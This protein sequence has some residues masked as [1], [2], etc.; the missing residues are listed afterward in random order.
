MRIVHVV[1]N[2]GTIQGN[3][4][5]VLYLAAGQR[6]RGSDVLVVTD[7]QGRFT[8][9]CDQQGTPVIVAKGFRL[10]MDIGSVEDGGVPGETDP[11]FTA[12]RD[13]L[14]RQFSSFRADLIHCHDEI[15]AYA[16]ISAGNR[17]NIPCALTV[18]VPPAGPFPYL[19]AAAKFQVISGAKWL[20][21]KLHRDGVPES[22]LHYVPNGTRFSTAANAAEADPDGAPR[23]VLV[24]RVSYEKGADIAI[25]AM[26]ELQRRRGSGCPQLHVYGGGQELPYYVE[27]ARVLGLQEYIKFHGPQFDIIDRCR[28]TDILVVTSRGETGP[29]VVLEAMSRGMPVVS[30]DV[31]DV[32]MMLP[33]RRYGLIVPVAKIVMLADAIDAT[34]SDV[35]DGRRDPDLLIERHRTLF[36]AENMA[37]SIESVYSKILTA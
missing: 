23:L 6:A 15:S 20:V 2:A 13:D 34:L 16:A 8:E 17:L 27:M 5:H 30:T 10:P 33:D 12:H 22:D 21:D 19:W 3:H 26:V 18:H 1:G 37:K 14:I 24:G 4:R 28:S 31:G 36:S 29:L 32:A 9:A 7:E 25:L 11:Q 35:A